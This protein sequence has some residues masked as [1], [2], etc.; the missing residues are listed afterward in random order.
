MIENRQVSRRAGRAQGPVRPDVALLR[1]LPRSP[2][3][4]VLV[5]D[6]RSSTIRALGY[7]AGLFPPRLSGVHV[8]VN[9]RAAARLEDEWVRRLPGVLLTQIECAGGSVAE[10]LRPLVASEA[11]SDGPVVV[12]LPE[13]RTP[14]FGALA[15]G[16]SSG[17]L[18]QLQDIPDTWVVTLAA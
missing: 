9:P 4:V 3:V 6:V 16:G 15:T 8:R 10:S 14:V 12:V 1:R 13:R 5:D 17:I 18:R 7:G 11:A 2:N